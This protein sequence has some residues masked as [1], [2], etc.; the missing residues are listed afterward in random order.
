MSELATTI[1][2]NL[3][4]VRERIES[5]A[6]SSGRSAADVRLVAVTKYTSSAVARELVIAGCADLGESRPQELWQKAAELADLPV[7]W[8][9][10]GSLQR[11]K[12]RRTLD[13]VWLIHSLDRLSLAKEIDAQCAAAQSTDAQRTD[14]QRV[15]VLLEINISGEAAKHGAVPADAEAL[16]LAAASSGRL[17]VCGLMTMASRDGNLDVARR[18]F[19]ALR[20]LRDKLRRVAPPGTSLDELSMGMSGDF[21]VA[22]AEG[23]TIVRVGSALCEGV[24]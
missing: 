16:L 14:A 8:H 20:E 17:D 7:R 24:S 4:H 21:E 19:A 12:V 22:I 3:A 2:R 11:N 15:A 6:A 13:I 1:R 23:A 9:L 10:I 5:A 18:E